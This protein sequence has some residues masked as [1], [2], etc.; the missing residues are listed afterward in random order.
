MEARKERGHF[1]ALKLTPTLLM[2]MHGHLD[3]AR[4]RHVGKATNA[5]SL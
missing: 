1:R 3:Q 2:A 5:M 4:A